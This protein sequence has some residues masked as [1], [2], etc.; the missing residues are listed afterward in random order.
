MSYKEHIKYETQLDTSI[1]N[2]SAK[3]KK[4]V[5]DIADGLEDKDIW[6]IKSFS[7]K[8]SLR[9]LIEFLYKHSLDVF[10]IEYGSITK[11]YVC[12]VDNYRIQNSVVFSIK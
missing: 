9:E 7:I 5:R 4:F 3:G 6:L 12:K 1:I 2:Q 10:D 11:I 8:F